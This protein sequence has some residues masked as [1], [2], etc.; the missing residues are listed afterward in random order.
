MDSFSLVNKAVIPAAGLGT[1]LL[2][3]TKEL[4]KEM[5]PMP[6]KE[7][8]QIL[9]KPMLQIIFERL[10]TSDFNNFCFIIGKGK[11]SIEDHFTPE[12][13][14]LS[15]LDD[16]L[17]KYD[18]KNLFDKIENTNIVF[19]NQ[20][21]RLGFGDAVLR[22]HPFTGDDP[23]LV[24]A[25]DDLILSKNNNY[26]ERLNDVF[27]KNNADAVF[28][29]SEI[30]DPHKF[31][32]ISGELISKGVYKVSNI[33]EK[34]V[35]PPSNLAVIAIYIFSPKIHDALKSIPTSPNSELQLT[36]GINH[37]ISSGHNVYAVSLDE[38]EQRIEIG[39]AD[40][41]LSSINEL[42]NRF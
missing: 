1:R 35:I 30:D 3:I 17:W 41:Y 27:T 6:V 7:N 40:S 29:V 36:D 26:L 19:I 11:R 9:I 31:G 20:P 25:G 28:L 22:S 5:L 10:I 39:T 15:T 21:R 42:L 24:H 34:P 32:V 2:P 4:P 12:P 38:H 37:L 33:I 18:L 8:N 14:F 23:F 16:S 13:R